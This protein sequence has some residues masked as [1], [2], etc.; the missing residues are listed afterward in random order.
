MLALVWSLSLLLTAI[1]TITLSKTVKG[2]VMLFM[3]MVIVT[4]TC[5]GFESLIACV[6]PFMVK[7]VP[8]MLAMSRR[9]PKADVSL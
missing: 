3:M 8:V 6:S 7:F 9:K 1:I 5:A 4:L 2:Q